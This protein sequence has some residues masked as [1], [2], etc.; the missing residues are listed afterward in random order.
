MKNNSYKKVN[1]TFGGLPI[2]IFFTVL[3]AILKVAN[4]LSIS[5]LWVF[6]PIWLPLLI[7]LL[8]IGILI[9]L[10]IFSNIF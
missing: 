2:G 5:W 8:V 6:S 3:L 4:V 10:Y 1:I 7:I 9:T